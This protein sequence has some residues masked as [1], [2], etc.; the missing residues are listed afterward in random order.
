MEL[1]RETLKRADDGRSFVRGLMHTTINLRP[2]LARGELRIELQGQANPIH[3]G[4]VAALC[5]ELNATETHYP[6]TELLLKYV[7]LRSPRF[8]RGQDV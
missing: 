5:T 1:A 7:P 3:D 8:P 6:G 2:D 4:A